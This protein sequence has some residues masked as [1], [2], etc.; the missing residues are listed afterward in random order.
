M[1][2]FAH[3][4]VTVPERGALEANRRP[5][6]RPRRRGGRSKSWSEV[7]LW[8]LREAGR[9]SGDPALCDP[10]RLI[11]EW[12]RHPFAVALRELA[13]T[14]PT[15]FGRAADLA[16]IEAPKLGRPRLPGDW[17]AVYLAYV[18]SGCPAL[19]PW[20]NRSSSSG[21][22]EI[23]GFEK[24]PSYQLVHLRFAEMEDAWPA[25][26]AVVQDLIGLAKAADPR[27]GEIV[28][29]DASGWKSSAV[30]EHACIDEEACLRAGGKP[31]GRL[32][33]D[34]A[35]EVLP[36][37]WA[38]ADA[39]PDQDSSAGT[40]T[41][42]PIVSARRANGAV[43]DYRL[44]TVKEH[45]YRS[46][47]TT[48]GL[49]RYVGARTWFGGFYLAAT[50]FFTGLPLAAQVFAADIQE[51][52]GVPALYRDLLA[53]VG[54]LPYIVSVDKG[55]ATRA[56]HEFNTRRGIAVVGPRRKYPGRT[57]LRDWRT[58]RFDEHGIPRCQYCGGEGEQD[59]PG[60]GLA[61]RQDDEPVIRFRCLLPLR[62]ECKRTQS[63]RCS[64]EWL[65]LLPLSRTTELYHAVRYA[66]SNL[67]NTFGL[68]RD[69]FAI[70]GKD[71]TGQ[72]ARPGVPPQ[73]LRASAGLLLDWFRLVLRQGWL[74]PIA[75]ALQP[76]TSESV[77]LSGRRDRASGEIMHVGVGAERLGRLRR[78]RDEAQLELP[79]GA[80]WEE[81]KRWL[82]LER[83]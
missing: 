76:T 29:V 12:R 38:E 44:F 74:E 26:I 41:R 43:V 5:E 33:S 1:D 18:L 75:L 50:D 66:R 58:D 4:D 65:M 42:G 2:V 72:L 60:M 36:H 69:R 37:H 45:L 70:A 68:V 67:E 54:E 9:F 15:S 78:E 6:H 14:S 47:D 56:F 77:L 35:E 80:A 82:E 19:Q 52:E 79:Y 64:E 83:S 53:A 48:S 57:E 16:A 62:P 22:W 8:R 23:C 59:S 51:W 39:D 55:F 34:T 3:A 31:S 28:F 7:E 17:P 21:L 81:T 40:R 27:I 32:R 10:L 49:R 71:L 11:A 30:L 20:Y 46:L 13:D 24:R 73:R 25:F 63:I 61:F